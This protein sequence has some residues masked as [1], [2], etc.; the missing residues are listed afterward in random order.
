MDVFLY[1]WFQNTISCAKS[2]IYYYYLM[3]H[4][5]IELLLSNRYS[6]LDLFWIDRI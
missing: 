3:D 2:H 1:N 6:F 5:D 4:L